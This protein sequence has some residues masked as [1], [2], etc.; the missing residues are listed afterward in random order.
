MDKFYLNGTFAYRE[1]TLAN[2]TSHNPVL[3]KGEPAIVRDGAD[4]EW[5]KIG[6]G[7]TAWND[8][9]YKKG[10]KGDVGPI[11]PQ[12][13]DGKDA[14]IDQTFDPESENAQSGKAVA[15]AISVKPYELIETITIEDEGI[16]TITRNT[17]PNGKAYSFKDVFIKMKWNK[18]Q[19]KQWLL[20]EISADGK[21]ADGF[22]DL[23]QHT[24]DGIVATSWIRTLS[25]Y[26]HRLFIF[27]ER[28]TNVGYAA[29]VTQMP[30]SY[31]DSNKPIDAIKIQ[32]QSNMPT[33]TIIEIYGVRA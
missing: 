17:E 4:G 29:Y 3:E 28:N 20:F 15:E 22:R 21:K 2:W 16:S 27:S 23:Y 5:L 1:D 12:G 7:V 14:I 25:C 19:T 8:L 11:G 6:D 26:G 32:Y 31:L 30:I 18:S 13:E 10:P 9:P 24:A 33:G